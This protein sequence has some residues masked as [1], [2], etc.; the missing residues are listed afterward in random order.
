[1]FLIF[2]SGVTTKTQNILF[3]VLKHCFA[4]DKKNRNAFISIDNTLAKPVLSI[5]R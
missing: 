2:V 4:S 1:M 5:N 3:D